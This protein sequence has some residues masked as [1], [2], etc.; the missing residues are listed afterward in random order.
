MPLA[1]VLLFT[2]KRF[3]HTKK[4]LEALEANYLADKTELFVVSDGPRNEE[5]RVEVEQVRNLIRN[6]NW[7]KN[8]T[9][10][11]NE[12]NR[13]LNDN[14]F[15]NISKIVNEHGKVIILEDDIYTSPYFLQ[16]MNDALNLYEQ[17]K[18]VMNI[19]GFAFDWKTNR[20]PDSYFIASSSTWGWATW[21]DRWDLLIKDPGE[22]YKEVVKRNFQHRFTQNG[23]NPDY[24]SQ[25]EMEVFG[26]KNIWDIKWYGTVM[27]NDGLSLYP[28]KSLVDNIGFDGSG[29]HYVANVVGH[30]SKMRSSKIDTFPSVIAENIDARTAMEAYF[31]SQKPSFWD[32][33]IY[34]LKL[35]FK[36]K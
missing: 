19:S 2:F 21:K 6:R 9:L 32:K 17:E 25:L 16:Y 18:K 15:D 11:V 34:K 28:N 13:G 5:E 20:L 35:I 8:V 26:K 31:N 29:T 4:T 33:A 7:C 36:L 1:P 12:T 22:I 30:K 24:F 3:S 23:S 27:L 14:F 10:L